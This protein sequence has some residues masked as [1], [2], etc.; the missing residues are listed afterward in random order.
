[1]SDQIQGG[2]QFAFLLVDKFSMF[3]LAAA[4][5]TFRSAN[6]LRRRR[7][8]RTFRWRYAVAANWEWPLDP[9]ATRIDIEKDS[10]LLLRWLS[11]FGP[12]PT[13]MFAPYSLSGVANVR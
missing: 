8:H 2:R 4:I 7:R 3:S 12:R 10:P 5:D 11:A 1:M 6:R 13:R 9:P